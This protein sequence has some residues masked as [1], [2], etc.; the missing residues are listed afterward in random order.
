MFFV[1]V[2]VINIDLNYFNADKFEDA[3]DYTAANFQKTKVDEILLQDTTKFRVFNLLEGVQGAFN[4]NAK[5]A[6][7]FN[8]IG[9]YHAAKLSIYQDLVENQL[10]N[11]PNC[12]P[13]I[14]ML[15]TKYFIQRDPQ[16]GQPTYSINPNAL[17][18]CWFVKAVEFKKGPKAVMNALTNLNT[19]DSAVVDFNEKELVKYDNI[20]D[21]TGTI[22]L[23]KNEND[24]IQYK[25]NSNTAK[26]AVFSE[27]Y[28]DAG[29]KAYIDGKESPI[30]KTN[31]V[32]RGL[33]VPAGKHDI[34]FEFKPNSYFSSL[35]ISHASLALTWIL[36]FGTGFLTYK[37]RK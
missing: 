24:F 21:S 31:Y 33:S 6:Y 30:I 32:L 27:V 7:Y 20:L 9:G 11:F 36:L 18:N 26:F 15:N 16:N 37:N 19:K 13:V 2:D 3:A 4:H 23:I 12:M 25:S 35:K 14:N 1:F 8:S 29:W 17:G 28:Y 34:T 10:Y 22:S 5:S